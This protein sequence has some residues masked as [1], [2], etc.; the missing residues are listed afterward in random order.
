M[1]NFFTNENPKKV[2]NTSGNYGIISD[3]VNPAN[4]VDGLTE[5]GSAL[6]KLG[7]SMPSPMARLFLFTAALGEVNAL[8]ADN[9]C[10]GHVGKFDAEG[11]RVK[12]PYHDLVG[13]LLDMLE[14]IFKYGDYPQ[15]HVLRWDLAPECAKLNASCKEH[16]QLASALASAF[17]FGVLQNQPIHIF[18]WN[19]DVIGGSSPVSLVYTSANL[20]T[21]LRN[22]DLH[23]SGD[24]G[25]PLFTYQ[26]VPLNERDEK[27]K[28]YLYRLLF[29]DFKYLPTSHPLYQLYTYIADSAYNYDPNLVTKVKSNS[30]AYEN[31]KLLQSQGANVKVAVYQDEDNNQHSVQLRVSNHTVHINPSTSDY[32]L[33]PTIELYKKGDPTA[34]TP[35]ALTK[36][37]VDGLTYAAGRAWNPANDLIPCALSGNINGRSL[38]G[39]GA[40]VKYPYLTVDDFFEEKVI[41]V[42][43]GINRKKFFTGTAKGEDISFLLP[44]KKTFFEYFKLS[45]L[46]DG[47]GN[48]TD[49]LTVKYDDERE[50][51][52]V[53]LNLPLVNKHTISFVKTYDTS[54][55][56]SYKLNCYDAAKTFDLA[57]FPFY[58]L[59][60]AT[61]HNVYNVMVGS[62][63]DSV[64]L[65]FIEPGV[66][67]NSE[68]ASRTKKS[69]R[70]PLSTEHIHVKGA[71][72]CIEVSLASGGEEA[73]GLIIPMFKKVNSDAALATE[74]F[75]FS[76]D[77]G[78]SNTHVC[79]VKKNVFGDKDVDSFEYGNADSQMV[80]L[81]NENGPVEFASFVTA[82]KREFVPAELGSGKV[83][84]PMRTATYQAE[85]RPASLEMFFN[86]NIGFNYSEDISLSKNYKTN[87]KWDRFDL[88]ATNRM[89]TFFTQMLWMMKNK[90]VLN[91]GSD[92]FRLVVTY[93]VAMRSADVRN[94]KTAWDN[95]KKAVQCDVD[96]RYRTESVAPY[97]SYL[98]VLD[99]GEPYVN[100]D[101]GGGTTDIL[102]VNPFSG[103]SHVFSA[104]FAANDL[105]NDG[106]S[107]ASLAAKAN[108]FLTFYRDVMLDM[109]GDKRGE[110]NAVIESA[111][112]SADIISYLFANDDET[113]LSRALQ[114]S[115]TMLQL[116]V[117]HFSA[118]AFYMAYCL[119]T[120]EVDPPRNLS[121]TGMGSKYIRLISSDVEDISKIV[122]AIFHYAG[123]VLENQKL[124]NA[125]VAVAFAPD[126]KEVT[127]KGAL[128]S[129]NH[130]GAINPD[131]DNCFG[132]ED[133]D[134]GKTMHYADITPDVEEAVEQFFQKFTGLFSDSKFIDV[135]SDIGYKVSK[136]VVE[137]LRHY[138]VP[139][140]RQMKDLSSAGQDATDKLKEPMFFWPLKNSLYIIGKELAVQAKNDMKAHS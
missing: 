12:T 61:D 17:S 123:G 20:E 21:V 58:R 43:Y 46:F 134:P 30:Y 82:L 73:K 63:V 29:T 57:V 94:F 140:F 45:D 130:A 41:E 38:P 35:M 90:S 53:T 24:K 128:L 81:H 80:E 55:G 138:A 74:S 34:Q 131:V 27:F 105:W 69:A 7:S 37:G 42:S 109:L 51:L 87:I 93:P 120:V 126:P 111:S 115:P 108:G 100:M 32:I 101:I 92:T 70:S 77:F 97:Y 60:P 66:T 11:N 78:T 68:K 39:F 124:K 36:Y 8:E 95:A 31:V 114:T 26:A 62:T 139:S 71:F 33:A 117:I 99:Y 54:D 116:A 56:G 13:E 118:L 47:N 15:F 83:K 79:C 133:E 23:F 6:G 3:S 76:I 84:F 110:V 136:D 52:R 4:I 40:M 65:D 85:G 122:N 86:T 59:E 121:F 10:V 28:E 102:Y 50:T 67:V 91:D 1:A 9:P 125:S 129:L 72:S 75:A 106:I 137:K 14:F 64:S 22:A 25:K 112:S 104:F 88:L 127:A 119:H 132:F 16:V 96:I 89:S 107:P 18:K 49:M 113:H 48:Y 19:E 2:T 103:E 98:A 5:R 135:L 44:L